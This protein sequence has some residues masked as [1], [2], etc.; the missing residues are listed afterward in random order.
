M[1]RPTII[2]DESVS[3]AQFA[4]FEIFARRHNL[5]TSEC[6]FIKEAHPGM[7]DSQILLHYLDETTLLV[8]TDRPFHNTVLA[9]G[10]A[11][12][13]LTRRGLQTSPCP[14]FS[15]TLNLRRPK[16]ISSSKTVTSS[17]P[18]DCGRYY[19]PPLP[20]GSRSC[21]SSGGAFVTTFKGKI[22]SIKWPSLSVG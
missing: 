12:T 22:I 13:T 16:M 15:P 18:S 1:P 17:L 20:A 21:G 14:A 7:P 5:D 10:C 19:C 6:I 8:T 2:I 11:A 9:R 3:A 4:A